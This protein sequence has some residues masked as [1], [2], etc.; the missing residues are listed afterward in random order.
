M[1]GLTSPLRQAEDDAAW[2][3][4]EPMGEFTRHDIMRVTGSGTNQ[5]LQLVRRWLR[6]ERIHLSHKTSTGRYVYAVG[7][8]GGDHDAHRDALAIE[9]GADPRRNMWRAMQ[10]LTQ[11][12]PVDL[13]AVSNFAKAPVTER[14]AQ[15]FC[16]SLLRG[17]YLRVIEKAKPG[18]RPAVYR[19]VRRTGPKPPVERRVA[20]LFD[21][22]LGELTYVAG[23]GVRG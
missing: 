8:R 4:I 14:D 21:E 20:A 2:A 18:Q 12:S 23:I 6:M 3:A 22:N 19:L 13:A 16:Q 15:A 11:F 17:E 9:A 5:V 10:L 1:S 7:Q